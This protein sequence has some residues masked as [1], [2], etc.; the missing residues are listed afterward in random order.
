MHAG[1]EMQCWPLQSYTYNGTESCMME[2]RQLYAN[3]KLAGNIWPGAC[4]L[5]ENLL[6]AQ[7]LYS[8]M[9][10]AICSEFTLPFLVK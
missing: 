2:T 1:S 5:K 8:D 3:F 10:F 6:Y 9:H 4:C 7:T